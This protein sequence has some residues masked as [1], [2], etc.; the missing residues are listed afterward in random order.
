MKKIINT[1]SAPAPVGPYNQSVLYNGLLFVSGQIALDPASGALITSDIES[2]THRVMQNLQAILEAAGLHFGHVL[3][4][5]VFVKDIQMFGRINAV[6]ATYFEGVEA[7]ARE[8]VE[9]VN[10][11]KGGNVEISLI[12]GA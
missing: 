4:C 11:P 6:Y 1:P 7:P 2:E 3:K 10:L 5:T 12:A 8:L 9:V